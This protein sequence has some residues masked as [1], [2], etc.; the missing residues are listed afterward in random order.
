MKQS[1]IKFC[2]KPMSDGKQIADALFASLTCI[3]THNNIS[4]IY[5]Y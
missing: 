5:E 3:T 2:I 1:S 4:N